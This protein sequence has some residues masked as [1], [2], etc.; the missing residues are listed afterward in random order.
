MPKVFSNNIFYLN[1]VCLKAHI[2]S[3]KKK[4]EK[5]KRKKNT[6]LAVYIIQLACVTSR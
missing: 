4:N 6:P 3:V 1:T 2:A 5:K